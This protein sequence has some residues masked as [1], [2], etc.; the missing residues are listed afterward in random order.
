MSLLAFTRRY[1]TPEACLQHLQSIRWADGAYCPHCG[2]GRRI[3]HYADCRRH[4]C[5]DCRRVFRLTTGTIFGDSPLKLLP[6]WFAA[7]YLVTEHRKGISSVQLARD[8]G[9][10]QKTAWHMIHRIHKAA[11]LAA[12]GMLSGEVEI[13]ETYIG[14]KEKNKHACKRSTG[15]QGGG[16]AKT[17][18]VAFGMKERQGQ[19]RAMHIAS[20][21]SRAIMP[22][23]IQNIALGSNISADENTAYK[24][25]G[26][27][28]ALGRVNHGR[29]EWR[30]GSITTNG[31]ESFWAL[32]K[33]AYI[34]VH[35][36]WSRKHT[37]RY[38][39]GASFRANAKGL[40]G[41]ERVNA[42]LEMGM[43]RAARLPYSEL[44]A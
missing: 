31:I 7:I 40:D 13:D 16:S 35:H 39:D 33:R 5:A 36:W 18:A 41:A 6:Q 12:T 9:V 30:R 20:A 17:K 1:S 15:A 29:G 22:V 2:S 24:P 42:L 43:I 26:E 4:R 34:G 11:G 19:V 27:Y 21:G 28:Y 3:Y 14:G 38:L 8:I 23:V 10:T 44:K 32:V 25:L 37:Q